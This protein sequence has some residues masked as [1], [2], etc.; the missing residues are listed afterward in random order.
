MRWR[1]SYRQQ[2]RNTA[3]SSAADSESNTFLRRN[4]SNDV[5]TAIMNSCS[6]GGG[7]G[8][9]GRASAGSSGR[10]RRNRT[11]RSQNVAL[12]MSSMHVMAFVACWTPYL[13]ISLWHII[14][15][16]SVDQVSPIVQDALFLTAV[17]NSCINPFVYGGFYFRTQ[18]SAQRQS[19]LRR[20]FSQ[21]RMGSVVNH[22]NGR[23]RIGNRN[24]NGVAG[25]NAT[26]KK[27]RIQNLDS[28]DGLVAL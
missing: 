11:V 12:R 23:S 27:D 1:T 28:V 15:E 9:S 21:S 5:E 22:S 18:S 2:P 14:D 17:L 8:G 24:D 10:L 4:F 6:N 26:G 3:S 25:G 7:G 13:V 16:A 20:Q 19:L